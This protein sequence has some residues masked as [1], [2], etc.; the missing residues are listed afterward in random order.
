[1]Q[2]CEAYIFCA[3]RGAEIA[4]GFRAELLSQLGKAL[5]NFKRTEGI[6]PFLVVILSAVEESPCPGDLTHAQ[7]SVR[8]PLVFLATKKAGRSSRFAQRLRVISRN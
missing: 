1:M 4:V 3:R 6:A 7:R 2:N 5:S 8:A